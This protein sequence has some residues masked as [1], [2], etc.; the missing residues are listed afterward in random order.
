MNCNI[1]KTLSQKLV[2]SWKIGNVTVICRA[3]LGIDEWEKYENWVK[4]IRIK[5]FFEKSKILS[6]TIGYKLK[7]AYTLLKE[8]KKSNL[9]LIES[10]EWNQELFFYFLYNYFTLNWKENKKIALRLH[11]PLFVTLQLNKL[12][13]TIV[14]R[15]NIIMEKFLIDNVKTITTCSQSLVDEMWKY[16]QMRS[17]ISIIHNLWNDELFQKDCEYE[18]TYEL[19]ENWKI[20]I[21]FAWSLEY[22][23]WIVFFC[24]AMKNILDNNTNVNIVLS[25]KYG[26]SENANSKLSKEEI[27]SYFSEKDKNR[28][29]FLWLVPYEKMPNVYKYVDICIF[30]SIYDNYPWVV[31]ESLLMW[32]AVIWSKNTWIT[33]TIKNWIVYVDP[34]DINSIINET[35]ELLDIPEKRVNLWEKWYEEV[36]LLND[37]ILKKF[38]LYYYNLYLL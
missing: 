22:R 12:K 23:K 15:I 5:P 32:K 18:D 31:I 34:S 19:K 14:N 20:N 11:T 8:R 3:T 27:L 35:Q 17:D 6:E 30:P 16:H 1:P 38:V 10:P 4:I 26:G 2:K 24:K 13:N 7:V 9:D 33:E 25:W 37:D 21:L 28:I 36:I 29:I